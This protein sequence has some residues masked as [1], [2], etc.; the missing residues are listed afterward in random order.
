MVR[1]ALLSFDG[2]LTQT[3]ALLSVRLGNSGLKVSKIILGCMSYGD[4]RWQEWVLPEEE[5][6]KHIKYAYV[7][8]YSAGYMRLDRLFC[9]RYDH[10]ITTFDTANVSA[11]YGVFVG[12]LIKHRPTDLLSRSIR[13]HPRER[14]QETQPAARRARYPHKG[15]HTCAVPNCFHTFSRILGL[16]PYC[17]GRCSPRWEPRRFRDHQ[18]ARVES[19]GTSIFHIRLNNS[20]PPSPYRSISSIR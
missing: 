8:S 2:G 10:G 19:Q 16:L 18:P 12:F 6:I 1:G 11:S 14:H 9:C 5:A 13:D 3:L 4:P 7:K 20:P 15:A 17:Q